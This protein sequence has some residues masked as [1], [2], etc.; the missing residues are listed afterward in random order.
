M[1]ILSFG[2]LLW[3]TLNSDKKGDPDDKETDFEKTY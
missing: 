3:K 2:L 1:I